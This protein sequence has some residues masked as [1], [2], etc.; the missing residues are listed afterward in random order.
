MRNTETIRTAILSEMPKTHL[1]ST[2]GL[3]RKRNLSVDAVVS[4]DIYN[5][6]K[7]SNLCM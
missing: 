4:E 1:S 3:K 7:K 5:N 6:Y 2:S